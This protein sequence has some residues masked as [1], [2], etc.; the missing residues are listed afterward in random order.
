KPAPLTTP[1]EVTAAA[2]A[3]SDPVAEEALSLF[4]TCLG[5]TAGDLALVFMSRGGVFLT[6]GI[7][8]KILPALKTGNFR[9]AFEDKAPHSELMRTMPVYVITHPLAALSGLAAFARN[10]S[11]FGVQTAGRRWRA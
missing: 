10:P 1:A 3:K 8:Q 6:G 7:A 9:A 2:L 4:V 5:R 11:L